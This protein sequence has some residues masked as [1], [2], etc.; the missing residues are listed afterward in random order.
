MNRYKIVQDWLM[1]YEPLNKW[2]YMNVNRLES[3]SVSINSVSTARQDVTYIDGSSEKTF[4][5]AI[6]LSKQFSSGTSQL[7]MDAIE[8]YENIADW[9]DEQC[10]KGNYPDMGQD[11]C[12]VDI[13]RLDTDPVVTVDDNL[14]V[15]KYQSQFSIKYLIGVK[16]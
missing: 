6:S 9:I 13:E 8:E 5:F 4:V 2:I 10:S 16:E 3:D 1:Q 7:N 12:V 14:K 15:A 11:A